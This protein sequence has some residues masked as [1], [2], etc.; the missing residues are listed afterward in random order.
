MLNG[1]TT[2]LSMAGAPPD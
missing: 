2:S 1:S